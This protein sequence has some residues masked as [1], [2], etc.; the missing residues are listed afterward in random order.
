MNA[1][2]LT[3]SRATLGFSPCSVLAYRA[4][5]EGEDP[6][7]AISG[8]LGAVVAYHNSPEYKEASSVQAYKKRMAAV[9]EL[10][11]ELEERKAI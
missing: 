1:L 6:E 2:W 8:F 5:Q 11:E 7:K 3:S 9:K 10:E 4:E